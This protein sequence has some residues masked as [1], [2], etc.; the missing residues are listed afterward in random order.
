MH[1]LNLSTETRRN[2]L[3]SV[4]EW[5]VDPNRIYSCVNYSYFMRI[6]LRKNL[7]SH[8]VDFLHNLSANNPKSIFAFFLYEFFLFIVVIEY[9]KIL[10]NN[11][12]DKTLLLVHTCRYKSS[13]FSSWTGRQGNQTN[14]SSPFELL[15]LVMMIEL[16]SKKS[17]QSICWKLNYL[18]QIE[19]VFF[20]ITS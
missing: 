6:L 1:L 17:K 10:S 13:Y 7:D 12:K 4:L 8:R 19:L 14:F 16:H 11:S 3:F 2:S 9:D 20:S 5:S 15:V 18:L